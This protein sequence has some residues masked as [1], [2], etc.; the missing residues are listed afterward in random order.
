[1]HMQFRHWLLLLTLLAGAAGCDAPSREEASGEAL[2]V[3]VALRVGRVQRSATRG[4]A[5]V[6][7]EMDENFRGISE[8]ILVPF[9]SRRKVAAG[10]LA[11]FRPSYLPG[12]SAAYYSSARMGST[13]VS[14]LVQNNNAH[15]YP[16]SEAHLPHGTASVLAYGHPP[17]TLV[18]DP[19]L[20]KHLNGTLSP[21]GLER[22]STKRTA[23][24]ITF[25][26]V[27]IYGT[28]VPTE[29]A[30]LVR[31]LNAVASRVTYTATY[32]YEVNGIWKTGAVTLSWNEAIKDVT[33]QELF[34]WFTNGGA[35]MTGAGGNLEYMVSRLY[36]TLK[37]NYV[38]YDA[39]VYEH[40]TS[41]QV[42][43]A[44]TEMDEGAPLTYAI[45]YNGI[46]DKIVERIEDLQTKGYLLINSGD[47]K[48][49][50]AAASLRTYPD[51]YG[52]PSGAA[53]VRWNGLAFEAVTE[54]LH[55]V[56]AIGSYCYP[57]DL[58]FFANTTISTST[59]DQD[60]VY[61]SDHASW[62][63]D[64][65]PVYRNGKVLLSDTKS[66]ALDSALQYSC[67]MLLATIRASAETLDDADGL[68]STQVTVGGDRLPVTGVVV[69]SQRVL[70]YD[71]TPGA[72]T[73][74][75]LYDNCIDGV[76]LKKTDLGNAP[77]FR[78]LVSQTPDGDPVYFCLELRNDTGESFVGADG[79]VLPG[80]KFYLVGTIELPDDDSYSRVFERDHVTT[81]NCKVT[82]LAGARTAVP[83]LE[84]PHLS[85]G[86]QVNA[87]WK[88]STPTSLIL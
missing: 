86:L 5:S 64:I 58:W 8:M 28:G 44:R 1:M 46:R 63:R 31:L 21:S 32:Y 56:A 11:L 14:G 39:A 60:E 13:Y 35:L 16:D 78:T 10:D 18:E 42:Y 51:A 4:N 23:A 25:S 80:A 9:D 88:E 34:R 79:I 50:F 66:A 84:H 61:T 85:V 81:V 82:S 77:R 45:L 55:G 47:N 73:D 12:I 57:P 53:V 71:F 76:F 75:F 36:K 24:A 29:A 26:P 19:I 41:S 67:G 2:P 40:V 38:S 54:A 87:N 49:Q 22:N 37:E 74:Y 72:G 83:D 27:S 17:K 20:Q 7:T 62:T 68:V 70:N 69:G 30:A 33:L 6:I 65:L 48:V 15:L 52:L 3:Q 43:P 59:K